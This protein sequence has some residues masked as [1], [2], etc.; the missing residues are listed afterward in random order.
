M[1]VLCPKYNISHC[2]K[3]WS[4]DLSL[5]GDYNWRE[6]VKNLKFITK[7]TSLFWFQYS[8]ANRILGVNKY[9]YFSKITDS[10]TCALCTLEPESVALC[11][12][13]YHG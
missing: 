1:I 7:Y 10:R 11:F 3:K 2:A 9:L 13:M 12:L 4:K 6:I 5:P 8:I